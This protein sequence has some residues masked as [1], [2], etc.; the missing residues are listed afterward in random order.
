MPI[1][2]YGAVERAYELRSPRLK[3]FYRALPTTSLSPLTQAMNEAAAFIG[4]RAGLSV[5]Q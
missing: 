5:F 1:A 3:P 4:Q 2:R